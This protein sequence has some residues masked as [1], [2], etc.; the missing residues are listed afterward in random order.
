M[1]YV[2]QVEE[3]EAV[4]STTIPLSSPLC[5]LF[6]LLRAPARGYVGGWYVELQTRPLFLLRQKAWC[7]WQHFT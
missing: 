1:Q 4:I 7:H 3:E 6:H 5:C 2:I